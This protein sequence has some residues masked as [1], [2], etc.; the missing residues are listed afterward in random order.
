MAR[1]DP[2]AAKK[3]KLILGIGCLLLG[4][5]MAV[6]RLLGSGEDEVPVDEAIPEEWELFGDAGSGAGE[7]TDLETGDFDPEDDPAAPRARRLVADLLAQ[8]G[9]ADP[10]QAI[11]NPFWRP[12]PPPAPAPAPADVATEDAPEEVVP[13]ESADDAEE[14]AA[15]SAPLPRHLVSLVYLT[16]DVYRAIVDG[17]IVGVGDRLDLGQVKAIHPWGIVVESAVGRV[18]YALGAAD[19]HLSQDETGGPPWPKPEPRSP[20]PSADD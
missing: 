10:A 19:P 8:F 18:L 1:R 11:P 2:E 20:E 17:R 7:E 13:A 9:S 3:R 5:A 4:A 12:P 14:A 16:D 6:P 15:Q